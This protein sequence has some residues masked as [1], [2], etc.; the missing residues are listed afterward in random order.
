MDKVEQSSNGACAFSP[1]RRRFC[2][3]MTS[4]PPGQTEW[5]QHTT[6]C[7]PNRRAMMVKIRHSY[8]KRHRG[9]PKLFFAKGF[10]LH[11]TPNWRH[12]PSSSFWDPCMERKIRHGKAVF[13][14][15]DTSKRVLIRSWRMGGSPRGP[16]CGLFGLQASLGRG[17]SGPF[18]SEASANRALLPVSC[19]D[20]YKL[21]HTCDPTCGGL[22]SVDGR[23][24]EP[25]AT[26]A[27]RSRFTSLDFHEFKAA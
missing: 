20:P 3:R 10:G 15:F 4:D 7:Y 1:R 14:P 16:A 2:H 23:T 26:I 9:L 12:L 27:L 19:T 11:S 18:T 8:E 13:D 17:S 5:G 24:I 25:A 21:N 22:A 6:A